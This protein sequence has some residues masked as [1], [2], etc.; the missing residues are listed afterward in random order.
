MSIEADVSGAA[1]ALLVS[2]AVASQHPKLVEPLRFGKDPEDPGLPWSL[3]KCVP[4][5]K[6]EQAEAVAEQRSAG[7]NASILDVVVQIPFGVG[8]GGGL[9]AEA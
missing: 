1:K 3:Q 4:A 7:I 8:T 2:A 5:T 6:C 9:N